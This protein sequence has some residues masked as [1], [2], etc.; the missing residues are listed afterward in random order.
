MNAPGSPLPVLMATE[1]K[2]SIVRAMHTQYP[3]ASV[4]AYMFA[5]ATYAVTFMLYDETV[6]EIVNRAAPVST[7]LPPGQHVQNVTSINGNVLVKLTH[8]LGG[9]IRREVQHP[10]IRTSGRA[11]RMV[12]QEL[13]PQ[14]PFVQGL[15]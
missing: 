10:M 7:Q 12:W 6:A 11:E 3:D 2:T 4:K 1:L 15:T 13:R 5:S 14:H 9:Q 8:G